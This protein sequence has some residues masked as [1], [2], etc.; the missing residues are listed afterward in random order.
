M[1][2]SLQIDTGVI[3]LAINSD[4]SRIIAFNPN[5]ALFAEKFYRMLGTLQERFAEYGEKANAVESKQEVD[6]NGI[7]LNTGER[8]ALM[9]EV[10][11]FAREQI[12]ELFGAGT[13][14]IVFEDAL[15]IETIIQ[16][17]DGIKPFV[18]RARADKVAKYTNKTHQKRK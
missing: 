6:G 3:R 15:N 16:F 18:Q 7:P 14:Q 8:I 10:C 11:T 5:D 2:Q 13:S 12:D 1:T 4:E 9:K 17:F